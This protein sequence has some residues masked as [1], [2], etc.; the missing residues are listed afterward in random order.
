VACRG[1]AGD[2]DGA[3]DVQIVGHCVESLSTYM[4][5]LAGMTGVR[6]FVSS[7]LTPHIDVSVDSSRRHD[8]IGR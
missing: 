4:A 5:L 3:A 2:G 8:L 7:Q 1:D 6:Q